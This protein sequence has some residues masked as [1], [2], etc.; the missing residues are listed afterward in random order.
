MADASG[1]PALDDEQLRAGGRHD[2]ERLVD[3][4]RNRATAVTARP[5]YAGARDDGL[6]PGRVDPGHAL[7][8]PLG[9]VQ[10]ATRA[11]REPAGPTAAANAVITRVAGSMRR[12]R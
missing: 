3:L 4:S 11:E 7:A 8:V 2:V 6:R 9:D 5:S 12:T 10:D 1:H